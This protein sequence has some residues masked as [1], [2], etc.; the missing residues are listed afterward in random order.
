MSGQC[1]IKAVAA[2]AVYVLIGAW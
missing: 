1:F 2:P